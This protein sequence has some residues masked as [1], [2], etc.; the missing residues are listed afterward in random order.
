MSTDFAPH[1]V[2]DAFIALVREYLRI[3]ET[4][5]TS[6]PHHFLVRCAVLLPQIYAAGI[7]L[8]DVNLSDKEIPFDQRKFDSPMRRIGTLLG[9]YDEY[10][11]V[12]DPVI[13]RELLVTHLSDDLADIYGDLREPLDIYD[14]GAESERSE[15]TWRWKFNLQGHGGDHLVD[16]LRPIHRLVF[17]HLKPGVPQRTGRICIELVQPCS[18]HRSHRG[19]SKWSN[20]S[21]AVGAVE[22]WP[23]APWGRRM[24]YK[25]IA[26][27]LT[28]FSV[29]M[30]G[31][32]WNPSRA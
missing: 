28:G 10:A 17:D 12:F 3:V 30:F 1:G 32:S 2:L 14:Q 26:A 16:S 6:T 5:D 15:A 31:V 21:R 19:C 4:C 20:L 18:G 11:E 13:D 9:K 27:R 22:R 8:P 25:E 29:P 23:L 7:Q 24:R